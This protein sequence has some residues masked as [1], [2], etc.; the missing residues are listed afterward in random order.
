M[1]DELNITESIAGRIVA[2]AHLAH[3]PA[4]PQARRLTDLS[5]LEEERRAGALASWESLMEKDSTAT[6]FQT[7][8]W[9]MAWY[10]SYADQ[11]DPL[12]IFLVRGDEL[13]GLVP[14]ASEK[15]SNRLVFAGD[16]MCDY[17][18]VVAAPAWRR[19][20][21]AELL[22]VC[23]EGTRPVPFRL[24][25]TQPE[26]E[27]IS[28]VQALS[29]DASGVYAIE[30][31]HPC[32]RWRPLGADSANEAIK[33]KDVRVHYN[34]FKRQG[35]VSV[36]RIESYEGWNAVKEWVYEQHTLRQMQIGR[37][38]AFGDAR[39][40]EFYESFF[41]DHPSLVRAHVLRVAGNPVAEH[42]WFI[43]RGTYHWG[44]SSHDVREDR[45]SPPNVLLALI[46]QQAEADGIS[47]VDFSL[48]GGEVKERFGNERVDLPSVDIYFSAAAHRARRLRDRA[49]ALAKLAVKTAGRPQ[50]STLVRLAGATGAA[51]R[52][53]REVGV[54]GSL[55]RAA[56]RGRL[57]VHHTERLLIFVA[58]PSDV[59]EVE[60]ELLH[61]E[62]CEFRRDEAGDMLK[63]EGASPETVRDIEATARSSRDSFRKGHNLYTVLVG[64]RLASWGWAY[65]VQKDAIFFVESGQTLDTGPNAVAF[66][67]LYTVA[68]YRG[69]RLYPAL[70]SRMLRDYFAEG[71]ERVIIYC[72]ETNTASRRGIERAGFRLSEIRVV[73]R[74]LGRKSWRREE[75]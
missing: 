16:L 34:Y 70:L 71:A 7:P 11:Y 74:W 21:I 24:G 66:H 30:R 19:E 73:S 67:S 9:C 15:H 33:K 56:R 39:K 13:V 37:A 52:K 20:T 2:P 68:D 18:D 57:A 27:T 25:P 23:A 36:E 12:V 4:A 43:W 51:A 61:G 46:L 65:P 17:R 6:F 47:C 26:S 59:K 14:L 53:A 75:P 41:R 1:I 60:P 69:R 64:G 50:W 35:A 45:R 28:L 31:A 10:R 54:A 62:T 44:N 32:W 42:Y 29:G 58:T 40:R 22:R 5:A 3:E 8:A 49:V 63:F 38:P 48:G 55:A 72:V